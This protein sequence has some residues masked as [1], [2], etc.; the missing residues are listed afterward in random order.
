MHS[1][2]LASCAV[3]LLNTSEEQKREPKS[4]VGNMIFSIAEQV[5]FCYLGSAMSMSEQSDVAATD[6]CGY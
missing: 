4:R 2:L 1:L 3:L 6:P 5:R